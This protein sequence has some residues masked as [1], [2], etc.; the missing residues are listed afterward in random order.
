MAS[1]N[2]WYEIKE[3]VTEVWKKPK[4]TKLEIHSL[5]LL[6]VLYACETL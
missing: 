6:V 5:I 1:G 3:L 4:N 2:K